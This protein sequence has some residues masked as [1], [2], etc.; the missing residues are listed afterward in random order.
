MFYLICSCSHVLWLTLNVFHNCDDHWGIDRVPVR[1]KCNAVF[2][3]RNYTI[4]LTI[5]CANIHK[6]LGS[7]PPLALLT[8]CTWD[9]MDSTSQCKTCWLTLSQHELTVFHK[10]APDVTVCSAFSVLKC[11]H[12]CWR[13]LRSGECGG[14]S[15][16]VRTSWSSLVFSGC[17]K[18][19]RCV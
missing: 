1:Q 9:G 18:A 13:G 12:K 8:A 11:P 5:W 19:L 17:V 2:E 6:Y 4:S 10:A 15:M 16:A 14:Q 3:I 7:H